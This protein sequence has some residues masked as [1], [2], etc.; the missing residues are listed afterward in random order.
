MKRLIA[1]LLALCAALAPGSAFAAAQAGEPPAIKVACGGVEI[2]CRM[3]LLQWNGSA[4]DRK[5]TFIELMESGVEFPYLPLGAQIDLAFA[6]GAPDS[7]LL[8]DCLLNADGT[9]K[10]LVDELPEPA[11]LSFEQGAASFALQPNW[12]SALSSNLADYAPGATLRGFRLICNWGVNQ[13][14]YAFIVRTDAQ[15]TASTDETLL[16]KARSLAEAMRRAGTYENALTLYTQSEEVLAQAEFLAADDYQSPQKACVVRLPEALCKQAAQALLPAAAEDDQTLRAL[17]QKICA[18]YPN[19]F[20]GYEGSAWLAVSTMLAQSEAF[21]L[22]GG[23]EGAAYVNLWYGDDLP[24]VTV[25]FNGGEGGVVQAFAVFVKAPQEDLF[26]AGPGAALAAFLG[27]FPLDAEELDASTIAVANLE[28]EA[29]A[30][31]LDA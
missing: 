3:G 25:A 21:A 4:Y 22:P 24:A 6:G 5:D 16:R 23:L 31:A 17:W 20:N 26:P 18:A 14:E 11:V 15:E 29:L 7:A 30:S 13:C 10:Y 1:L 27:S 2:P 9:E 19:A 28:G 12:M 8:R